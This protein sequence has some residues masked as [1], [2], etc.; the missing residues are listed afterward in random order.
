MDVATFRERLAAEDAAL[1]LAR[2]LDTARAAWPNVDLAPDAFLAHLA[3]HVTDQTPLY[4]VLARLCTADLYLAAACAA[5]HPSAIVTFDR[6]CLSSIADTL[7]RK[8]F[9]A[10]IARE[11]Q[12]GLREQLLVSASGAPGIAKYRGE[13]ELRSWVRVMAVRD[14]V[15]QKRLA[16]REP[17]LG[18]EALLQSLVDE[19]DL[20]VDGIKHHYREEFRAAFSVAL[21]EL[22]P[23]D[24][25]IL[26][27]NLID[28]LSIDQLAVVYRQ[29]RATVARSLQRVRRTVAAATLAGLTVRLRVSASELDSVLKLIRSQLDV[30]LGA[31]RKPRRERPQG[32]GSPA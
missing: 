7:T 8:G 14:A 20:E 28:G 6:H 32:R 19:G 5:G 31:I 3:L 29:H 16:A 26:R 15:R 2:V 11:V 30:T 17:P 12:Q 1:E 23:R 27:Q 10:D 18:D 22:P 24:K 25:N 9:D 21:A 4:P 13:G